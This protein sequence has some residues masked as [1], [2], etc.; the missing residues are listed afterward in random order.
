MNMKD[1]TMQLRLGMLFAIL[2]LGV[3]ACG[4]GTLSSVGGPSYPYPAVTTYPTSATYYAPV[5]ATA[6]NDPL[7]VTQCCP[8]PL[9]SQYFTALSMNVAA[10]TSSTYA[11]PAPGATPCGGS[12]SSTTSCAKLHVA[13]SINDPVT[14]VVPTGSPIL[15]VTVYACRT[16]T[17][18]L[19]T[20]G[21]TIH[22]AGEPGFAGTFSSSCPSTTLKLSY[23]TSTGGPWTST[24]ETTASSGGIPCSTNSFSIPVS[25]T[26]TTFSPS[27]TDTYYEIYY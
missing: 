26:A 14:S 17:S 21:N 15:Y 5:A 2:A 9:S 1:K 19:C 12:D 23:S 6:T 27:T 7:S 11:T 20:T 24:G 4:G 25:T 16:D 22:T 13:A 18:S 10:Y 3:A 8:P